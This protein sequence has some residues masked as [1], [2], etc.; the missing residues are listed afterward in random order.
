MT[1]LERA[2]DWA[3][4]VRGAFGKK[5]LKSMP[6]GERSRSRRCPLALAVGGEVASGD[7][8]FIN[9]NGITF[10]VQSIPRS[11]GNFVDRFDAGKYPQLE[12]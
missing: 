7:M 6:K 8:V 4:K 3:N 11:V 9:K 2:L 10:D 1:D 12:K 5:P